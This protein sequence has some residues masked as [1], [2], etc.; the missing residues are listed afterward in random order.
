MGKSTTAALF[1]DRG[2]AVW[3][4]DAAVHELYQPNGAGAAAISQICPAAVTAQGVDRQVLKE[5]IATD[6]SLLAKIEAAIHPLVADHRA[7]FREAADA[8]IC[9]FD[10]P[11]LYEKGSETEFDAVACVSVPADIQRQRVLARPNMTEQ[12]FEMIASKQLLNVEK[13]ARSDYV[14]DT[15]TPMTAATDVDRIIA[16]INDRLNH[17]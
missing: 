16:D 5:A 3:D 14:I 15:S 6:G 17:A 11:L 8:E 4:A 7:A 13:V 2:C 1:A 10:I 12:A 9:V